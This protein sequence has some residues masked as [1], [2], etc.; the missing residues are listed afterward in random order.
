MKSI[1]TGLMALTLTVPAM[2]RSIR[3]Q[4]SPAEK[5]VRAFVHLQT[6]GD[7]KVVARETGLLASRGF[8]K[9][10]PTSA[11]LLAGGGGF[12]G[13]DSVFLVATQ[14]YTAGS[15]TQTA[16]LGAIYSVSA[17]SGPRLTKVVTVDQISD[18]LHP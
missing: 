2:A 9:T 8:T 5:A 4:E 14:F 12:A 13:C 10:G 17:H 3:P 16:V 18:L 11:I 6:A 15:N 1:V 7:H